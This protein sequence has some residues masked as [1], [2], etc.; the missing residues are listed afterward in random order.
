MFYQHLYFFVETSFRVKYTIRVTKLKNVLF[1]NKRQLKKG[2]FEQEID[3]PKVLSQ[4]KSP[5]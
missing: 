3:L 1:H 2:Y 5:F 4:R